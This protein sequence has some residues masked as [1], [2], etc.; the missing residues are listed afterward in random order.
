M[1]NF[2]WDYPPGCSGT[3]YDEP[4]YC[5][6]CAQDVDNCICPECPVCGQAGDPDCYPHHGMIRSEA[7]E[8]AASLAKEQHQAACDEPYFD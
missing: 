2:G 4:D 3:P 7:Q 8:Q 1:P 5:Q 6:I